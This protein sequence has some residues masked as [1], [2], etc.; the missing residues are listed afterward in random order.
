VLWLRRSVAGH[1]PR[2]PVFDPGG[3]NGTKSFSPSTF[4][5][6]CQYYPTIAPSHHINTTTVERA[7]ARS[8]GTF[9]QSNALPISGSSGYKMNV[10]TVITAV[11]ATP[12]DARAEH[13]NGICTRTGHMSPCLFRSLLLQYFE[14]CNTYM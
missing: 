4:V 13:H 12:R 3:Q 2:R 11:S 14:K 8:L 9:Q 5:F 10:L 7:S 1:L 6:P